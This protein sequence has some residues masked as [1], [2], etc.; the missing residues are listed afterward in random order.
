[1]VLRDILLK[2]IFSKDI[3]QRLSNGQIKVN[4]TSVS[5][6]DMLLNVK[7]EYVELPLWIIDNLPLVTKANLICIDFKDLFGTD[8]P[9]NIEVFKHFEKFTL[10]SIS[11]REHF[12]FKNK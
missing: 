7:D 3:K 12:V 4:N 6:A 2:F 10:V 9:T 11:K 5:N 8:E 1:M